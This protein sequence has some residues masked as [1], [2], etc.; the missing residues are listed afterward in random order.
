MVAGGGSEEDQQE[1]G[2]SEIGDKG[3]QGGAIRFVSNV[4]VGV[5]SVAPGY[6]IATTLG[7]IAAIVSLQSPVIIWVLFVPMLLIA[8][9]YYYMNRVDPDCGTSFSWVT[10]SMGP[11]LG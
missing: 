11:H 7:F 4:V 8:T 10:T 6:S 9:A 5:A 1:L 3:L 2:G